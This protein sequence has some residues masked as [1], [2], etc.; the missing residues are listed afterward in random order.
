MKISP[1]TADTELQQ[2]AMTNLY[3]S[4]YTHIARLKKVK[5]PI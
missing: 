4:S 2:A 1:C 3:K 5:V